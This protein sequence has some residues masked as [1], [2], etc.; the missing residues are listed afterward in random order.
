MNLRYA[1]GSV[2]L[3]VV[4][5]AGACGSPVEIVHHNTGGGN[6]TSSGDTGG[7]AGSTGSSLFDAG[8]NDGDNGDAC[9]GCTDAPAAVCGDGIVEPG[10]QCDDG[11][12]MPG[13]GCSG[14]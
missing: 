14:I 6:S 9:V 12:S 7:A 2:A 10:E 3:S 8:M 1:L 4:V 5:A 11:N 13:D